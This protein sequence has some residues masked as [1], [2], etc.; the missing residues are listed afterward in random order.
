M[1][2]ITDLHLSA[3]SWVFC[4]WLSYLI[5]LY[6]LRDAG[7][8]LISLIALA[9]DLDEDFFHKAG[10]CDS[11]NGFLRLLHYPGTSSINDIF[12]FEFLFSCFSFTKNKIKSWSGPQDDMKWEEKGETYLLI[13]ACESAKTIFSGWIAVSMLLVFFLWVTRILL[14]KHCELKNWHSNGTLFFTVN[15]SMLYNC[16]WCNTCMSFN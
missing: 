11:P 2:I 14:T 3:S 10:A 1:H 16:T 5:W 12:L 9:L 7:I 15:V 6:C 13:D 4:I 8:R